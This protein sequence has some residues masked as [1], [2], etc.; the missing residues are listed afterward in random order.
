MPSSSSVLQAAC[1]ADDDC[2]WLDL[3]CKVNQRETLDVVWGGYNGTT[4]T[5]YYYNDYHDD[6]EQKLDPR[7]TYEKATDPRFAQYYESGDFSF[8]TSEAKALA[9][10]PP[11]KSRL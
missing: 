7:W 11:A 10:R 1:N 3:M 4:Q 8:Y 9:D 6:K 2:I 5:I